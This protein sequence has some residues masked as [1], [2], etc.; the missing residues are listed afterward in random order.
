M[1]FND[2]ER[3][4]VEKAAKA[5]MEKHRPPAHIRNELD[6]AFRIS[7]QSLEIYEIRPKWRSPEEKME[8]P[9]AK[10]TYVK[11]QKVWKVYWQR[12]DLKWHAYPPQ[13]EVDSVEK[14]LEL[15][16]KDESACFFG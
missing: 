9:A 13:P 7:G 8:L 4:R 14:F 5:F 11:T 2:L 16:G 10:A 15:V 3:K 1:A 6:L 12:R